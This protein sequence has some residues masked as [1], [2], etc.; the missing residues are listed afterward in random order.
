LNC[1]SDD[2]VAGDLLELKLTDN[3]LSPSSFI[4]NGASAQSLPAPV[5]TTASTTTTPEPASVLLLA[6]GLLFVALI[7]RKSHNNNVDDRLLA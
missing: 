1:H 4:L 6:F 3:L 5:I 2:A 7:T